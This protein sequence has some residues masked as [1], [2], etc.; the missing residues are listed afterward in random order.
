MGGMGGIGGIMALC[1]CIRNRGDQRVGIGRERRLF[2]FWTFWSI[3]IFIRGLGTYL[4]LSLSMGVGWQGTAYACCFQ[5]Q[6]LPK[7]LWNFCLLMRSS[8]SPM[9]GTFSLGFAGIDCWY[10]SYL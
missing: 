2:K 1:T 8:P 6:G 4:S 9:L 3:Q 10:S 5:A 7:D